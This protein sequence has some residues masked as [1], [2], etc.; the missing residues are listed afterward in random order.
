MGVNGTL[1]GNGTVG[2]ATTVNGNLR[3]GTSPGVLT[4]TNS[5]TLAGTTATTMEINGT[6]RE[7]GYDGVDVGTA[8]TYGGT[9]TLA[10]GTTFGT[11]QTFNLF[12]LFTSQSGSFSSVSLTGSYSGS[13]VDDGFG[14]WS[15]TTNSGNESWVFTQSTGDL[16]LTVIPEPS[17]ALLGALGAMLL[18]R[19]RR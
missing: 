11:D 9:L 7:T 6:V 10:F 12:D 18:L 16:A 8:L 14:V 19:R 3:P 4:F 2:G 15:A 1:G 13:L 17:S 5:L